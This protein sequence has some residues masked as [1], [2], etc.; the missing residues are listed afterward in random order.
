MA[1][2]PR[3]RGEDCQVTMLK[4][5]VQVAVANIKNFECTFEIEK[6]EE[7]YLGEHANRYDD[8]FKGVNFNFEFHHDKPAHFQIIKELIDRASR[9]TPTANFVVTARVTYPGQ[10]TKRLTLFDCFFE[11]TG[12]SASD[13]SS[14]FS[15]KISG[16][17]ST[18]TFI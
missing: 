16:S 14:Y 10:A 18:F 2:S 3:I 11:G 9:R 5:G 12:F 4:N 7:Q 17:S 8:I 6:K 15:S 1:T 13:R